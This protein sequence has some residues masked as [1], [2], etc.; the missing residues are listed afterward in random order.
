MKT[1][2]KKTSQPA[3]NTII[4]AKTKVTTSKIEALLKS[5]A[6]AAPAKKVKTADG[7]KPKKVKKEKGESQ[8]ASNYNFP[9]DCTSA[10]D[11]KKFRT[12]VRKKM[13]G[14]KDRLAIVKVGG[15]NEKA[16]RSVILREMKAYKAEV[17]L[18]T[19]EA[20]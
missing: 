9:K 17:Y 4:G 8:R 2:K 10:K 18:T 14:F 13:A 15:K 12:T 16:E 11:R 19:S 6:E 20:E 1:K 5:K 7:E 3:P